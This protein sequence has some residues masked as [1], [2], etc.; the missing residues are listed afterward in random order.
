MRVGGDSGLMALIVVVVVVVAVV[1]E[2]EEEVLAT[3]WRSDFAVPASA[4]TIPLL[5]H[6]SMAPAVHG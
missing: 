2:E 4:G 5:P 3:H 1:V 6:S